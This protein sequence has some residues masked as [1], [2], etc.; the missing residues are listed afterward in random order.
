MLHT[1]LARELRV[2]DYLAEDQLQKGH[3]PGCTGSSNLT[4]FVSF[5]FRMRTIGMVLKALF[6]SLKDGQFC[7]FIDLSFLFSNS[8]ETCHT[9]YTARD[10]HHSLISTVL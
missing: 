6:N 5:I 7:R 2:E 1:V 9:R 10:A 3:S 8:F 4:L